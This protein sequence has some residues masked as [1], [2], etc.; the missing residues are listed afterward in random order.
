M[1]TVLGRHISM[2][3]EVQNF[4][5]D[6]YRVI[7]RIEATYSSDPAA[8][9]KRGLPKIFPASSV[10]AYGPHSREDDAA[11]HFELSWRISTTGDCTASS[12]K[13][14]AVAAL[15]PATG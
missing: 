4:A 2:L 12:P 7:G 6:L 10:R 14:Q 13:L 1:W 5:S 8:A 9:L 11:W 15:H 3:I